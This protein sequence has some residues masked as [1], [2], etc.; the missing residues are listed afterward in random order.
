MQHGGNDA[1]TAD[2]SAGD[3]LH[4]F[5]GVR[6]DRGTSIAQPGLQSTSQTR[7]TPASESKRINGLNAHRS[8]DERTDHRVRHRI[9]DSSAKMQRTLAREGS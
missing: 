6:C 5:L 4:L 2:L 1:G 8:P 7:T 9:A 3:S